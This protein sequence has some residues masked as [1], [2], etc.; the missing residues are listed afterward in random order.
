MA[1]VWV[2]MH[3]VE[4]TTDNGYYVA[5]YTASKP[6]RVYQQRAT[7]MAKMEQANEQSSGTDENNNPTYYSIEELAYV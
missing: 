4:T 1:N 6:I 7:A 3:N 5:T 2:L